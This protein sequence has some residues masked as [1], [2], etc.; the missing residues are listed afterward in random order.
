LALDF[1]RSLS[2]LS[3]HTLFPPQQCSSQLPSPNIIATAASAAKGKRKRNT[4][5]PPVKVGPEGFDI[6][7]DQLLDI[8]RIG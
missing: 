3:T 4:E 7:A 8:F 1:E 5:P 2:A 6:V